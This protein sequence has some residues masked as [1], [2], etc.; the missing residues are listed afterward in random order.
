MTPQTSQPQA[1]RTLF[2][3]W[4]KMD[5]VEEMTERELDGLPFGAIQL[6]GEGKVLRYNRTEAE[7]SGLDPD[8]V[9]GR[10]FFV[11]IAPCTNVREF[12][13]KFREGFANKN[14]NAVF[15]YHFDFRMDPTD[16][17]VRLF[18][19]ESTNSAWVFVTRRRESE[20]K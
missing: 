5:K 7:I 13:G 3:D 10:D 2:P 8:K 17:W 12:G 4:K 9:V 1:D 6:N 14:L 15:P 16:V 11:E 20:G 19:S 18:Y